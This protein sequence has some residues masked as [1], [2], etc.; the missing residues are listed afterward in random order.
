MSYFATLLAK[1]KRLICVGNFKPT[2]QMTPK[3][4]KKT[5]IDTQHWASD[6]TEKKHGLGMNQKTDNQRCE[7]VCYELE[8]IDQ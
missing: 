7:L 2:T 5:A 3:H 1:D 6:I 4:Q 8:M